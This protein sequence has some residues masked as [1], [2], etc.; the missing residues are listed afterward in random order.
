MR[1][2]EEVSIAGYSTGGALALLHTLKHPDQIKEIYLWSPAIEINI[3]GASFT[4]FLSKFIDWL[5]KNDPKI[6]PIRYSSFALNAPAQIYKLTKELETVSNP[7]IL[8][9]NI[10]ITASLEDSTI[11]TRGAIEY[12]S[13]ITTG[14][15]KALIYTSDTGDN[16]CEK[17]LVT[18]KISSNDELNM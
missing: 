10:W 11:S 18:C 1:D 12:I 9:Q 16:I 17:S 13:G 5:Q 6:D 15:K 4:P 3:A 14:N 7:N 8:N 2:S